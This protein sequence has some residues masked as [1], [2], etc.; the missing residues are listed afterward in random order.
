M[1]ATG[2]QALRSCERIRTAIADT[3]FIFEEISLDLT[4]S[5]GVAIYAAAQYGQDETA[6]IGAA[7][8]ALYQAKEAGRNCTI[9][10]QS[11]VAALDDA[12]V[13]RL[14]GNR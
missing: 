8:D 13:K 12:K 2:D 14:P 9:L 10:A 5:C 1:K 11:S 4:I 7:D 6:L 3:P